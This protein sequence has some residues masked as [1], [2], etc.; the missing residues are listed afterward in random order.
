MVKSKL[1]GNGNQYSTIIQLPKIEYITSIDDL[2][3]SSAC[4]LFNKAAEF[5]QDGAIYINCMYDVI[6]DAIEAVMTNFAFYEV[7]DLDLYYKIKDEAQIICRNEMTWIVLKAIGY[8]LAK[9]SKKGYN[10]EDIEI[11][12]HAVS[13]TT[14]ADTLIDNLD[15]CHRQLKVKVAEITSG[16][17]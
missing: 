4:S 11:G 9:K 8:A 1:G 17:I 10:A 2:N 3:N 16:I 7:S 13:L 15:D 14:H 12:L 6:D 5:V